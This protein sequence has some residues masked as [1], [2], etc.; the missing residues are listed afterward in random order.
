LIYTTGEAPA[1]VEIVHTFA[2]DDDGRIRNLRVY[3]DPGSIQ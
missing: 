2:F 3:F 1:R